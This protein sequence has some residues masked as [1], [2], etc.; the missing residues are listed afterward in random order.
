MP[1]LTELAG[2]EIGPAPFRIVPER[3]AEFVAATGDDPDR[4]DD[5]APPG[6]AAAVLFSIAPE[7]LNDERVKPYT[8][9][10]IHSEQRFA[11][12]GLLEAG[13]ELRVTATVESVRQRS[14]MYLVGFR[15]MAEDSE[16]P[17]LESMSTFLMGLGDG[18]GLAVASSEEPGA[19]ESGVSDVPSYASRGE[20]VVLAKSAS[21]GDILRYAAATSDWNPIH[22]DHA[23]AQAAGLP[24]IVAHGLLMGAWACQAAT[25]VLGGDLGSLRL[26]FRKPLRPAEQAEARAT[27]RDDGGA[28]VAIEARGEVLVTGSAH[29]VTR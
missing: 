9:V 21:R 2:L 26:R 16:T 5:A 20:E 3:V 14:G 15:A 19:W 10:L 12:H 24:G 13:A 17:V 22:W 28:D 29:E 4:W 27:P 7:F 6:F 11:W 1:D 25:S 18:G 23:S 8:R